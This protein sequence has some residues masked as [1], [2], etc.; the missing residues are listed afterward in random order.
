MDVF[1]N[2]CRPFPRLCSSLLCVIKLPEQAPTKTWLHVLSIRNY[3]GRHVEDPPTLK[4]NPLPSLYPLL[5]TSNGK[6]GGGW[7]QG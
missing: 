1:R 2:I 3:V 5:P 4:L 7:E 6:L